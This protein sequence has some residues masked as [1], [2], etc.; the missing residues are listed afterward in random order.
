MGVVIPTSEIAKAPLLKVEALEG[1]EA[2]SLKETGFQM[3]ACGMIGSKR[4]KN[5]GCVIIGTMGS[6]DDH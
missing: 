6:I 5:D 2:A 1:P 4:G 3:N